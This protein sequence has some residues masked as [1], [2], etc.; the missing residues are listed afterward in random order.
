MNWLKR[1]SLTVVTLVLFALSWGGHSV[2]GWLSENE[3]RHEHAQPD[4]S[5]LAFLGSGTFCESTFENWESEFFQMSLFILLAAH[6]VQKG[7]A[8]SR[9]PG[10]EQEQED[11]RR[12]KLRTD[13]PY[14]VRK[15]GPVSKVYAHSLSLAFLLLFV[16]T[17]GLHA[18]YG[19]KAFSEEQLQH[20]GVPLSTLQY[21]T[22]PRFWYESFQNWQSEFL[23]VATLVVLSICLRE[24]D[25]P[26]SKPVTAPHTQTGS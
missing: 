13:S 4:E 16:V 6:L 19:A 25:S 10:D 7:A 21:L 20:G 8:E 1:S 18:H 9:K 11:E 22:A 14:P 15:G 12:E 24:K 3:E 5:Y 23:S 2:A 17:F 26:E